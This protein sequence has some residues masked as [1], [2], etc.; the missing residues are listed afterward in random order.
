[1]NLYETVR[2]IPRDAVVN[3]LDLIAFVLIT[4]ELIG[5]VRLNL[6]TS[7]IRRILGG[8]NRTRV[9]V[10]SFFIAGRI[11][12]YFGIPR[13]YGHFLFLA[14]VAFLIATLF[15][16]INRYVKTTPTRQLML[17]L[18]ASL[19]VCARMIGIFVALQ[20]AGRSASRARGSRPSGRVTAPGGRSRPHGVAMML[21]PRRPP[22][23]ETFGC[24]RSYP[25][26]FSIAS[27]SAPPAT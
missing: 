15:A 19:F 25:S 17:V 12:Q 9:I 3:I 26:P 21:H 7:W 14:G 4:P 24:R 22:D 16:L 27:S 2:P 13:G 1:M 8:Q 11:A 18:G 6:L 5:E 23:Q 10:A 20:A